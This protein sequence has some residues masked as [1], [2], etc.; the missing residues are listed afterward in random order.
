MQD[1]LTTE[2]NALSAEIALL[3]QAFDDKK[4]L[5]FNFNEVLARIQL[6]PLQRDILFDLYTKSEER[7]I[8][9][10]CDIYQNELFCELLTSFNARGFIFESDVYKAFLIRERFK[11]SLNLELFNERLS[12]KNG[13]LSFLEGRKSHDGEGVLPVIFHANKDK[14]IKLVSLKNFLETKFFTRFKRLDLLALRL[15][16]YNYELI[17]E[18]LESRLYERITYIFLELEPVF[19]LSDTF[20]RLQKN[21]TR[22]MY[23]L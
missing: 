4:G 9:L 8:T 3:R 11:E 18:L 16:F 19:S 12:F 5:K 15:D 20:K 2:I 23:I 22:N 6:S 13:F 17:L 21:F 10:L 14:N 7:E 1:T